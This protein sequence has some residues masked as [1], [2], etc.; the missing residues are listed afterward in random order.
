MH[1]LDA[2]DEYRRQITREPK[3]ADLYLRL[4]NITRMIGR[5]PESLENYRR[6]AELDGEDLGILVSA[7]SAEHDFGDL[8]EAERL[9]LRTIESG[10]SNRELLAGLSDDEVTAVQGLDF[11]RK[12]KR[13][14]WEYQIINRLGKTLV[15]PARPEMETGKKKDK[16]THRHGKKR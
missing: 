15:P 9:Y 14:P 12:G 16:R 7:A 4:G 5:Y 13:S 6:A 2:I 3:N 10:K 8:E 11:L 1:V